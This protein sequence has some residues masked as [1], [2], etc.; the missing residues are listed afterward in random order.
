MINLF[1]SFK[2][3]VELMFKPPQMPIL[4]WEEATKSELS[5]DTVI[6][7]LKSHSGIDPIYLKD[8]LRGIKIFGSPGSGKTSGSGK[9]IAEGMLKNRFGGLVLCVKN[10]EVDNWIKYSKI[11]GREKDLIVI[12]PNSGHCFNFIDEE[13][14][15][16]GGKIPVHSIVQLILDVYALYTRGDGNKSQDPFWMQQLQICLTHTIVFTSKRNSVVTMRGLVETFREAVSHADGSLLRNSINNKDIFVDACNH[17]LNKNNSDSQLKDSIDYLL[18]EFRSMPDKTRSIIVSMFRAIA[19]PLM[20]DPLENNF[21]GITNVRP[22]MTFEGKII[23][24]DI[25]VHQYRNSGLMAQL[26]WKMCFVNAVKRKR[27]VLCP[28]FLWCD[29][30]QYFAEDSDIEII[31]TARSLRCAI[32]YLTQSLPNLEARLGS[33]AK[34]KSIIGALNLSIFH[35]N[36]ESKTNEWASKTIG[37]V[38]VKKRSVSKAGSGGD[39]FSNSKE[40]VTISEAYECDVPARLF[41]NLKEG[42]SQNQYNVE[43]VVHITGRRLSSGKTWIK[44]NFDQRG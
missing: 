39:F 36:G 19:E 27:E 13:I 31:T 8:I 17:L 42:G 37:D 14:R 26:I 4:P 12:T 2:E 28:V 40:T 15:R 24:I 32:V 35:Q 29:E 23:V 25:S 21:C 33:D 3:N 41:T 38:L 10:D 1:K 22:E 6:F 20:Q 43:A 11:T 30:A 34:V 16:T 44:A 18:N 9:L 7:K 5:L